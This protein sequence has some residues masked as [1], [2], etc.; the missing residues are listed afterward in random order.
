MFRF[1]DGKSTQKPA[2]EIRVKPQ[3]IDRAFKKDYLETLG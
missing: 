2:M 3:G 1:Q